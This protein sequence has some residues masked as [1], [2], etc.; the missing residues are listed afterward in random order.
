MVDGGRRVTHGK[1]NAPF[2]EGAD[3][4]NKVEWRRMSMH[5]LGK[6]LERVTP[7]DGIDTIFEDRRPKVYCA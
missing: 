1:I 4:D 6:Y 7:L 5:L 2:G 3:E